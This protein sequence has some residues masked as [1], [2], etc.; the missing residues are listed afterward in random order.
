MTSEIIFQLESETSIQCAVIPM[1]DFFE[2]S[3]VQP[4]IVIE[5]LPGAFCEYVQQMKRTSRNPTD[6]D[7]LLEV[8]DVL[9]EPVADVNFNVV[10]GR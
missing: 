8:S 2:L 3:A 4:F 1:K 5:T 6:S 9:T 10:S 7:T